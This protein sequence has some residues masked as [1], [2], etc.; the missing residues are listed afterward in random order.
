MFFTVIPAYAG[1]PLN[2][3][4]CEKIGMSAFTDMTVTFKATAIDFY[5]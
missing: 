1:I 5:E 3:L 4:S 2:K